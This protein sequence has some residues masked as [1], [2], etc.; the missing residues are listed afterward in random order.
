MKFLD[1][2]TIVSIVG[3]LVEDAVAAASTL[4]TLRAVPAALFMIRLRREGSSLLTLRVLGLGLWGKHLRQIVHKEPSLL[5][6]GASVGDLEDPDDGSQIIIHGQLFLHLD[7]GDAHGEHGDNLLIGDPENLVP[8]LAEAL[9]VLAKRFA[10]VLMHRLEIILGGGALVR[11][12]E[13]GDKLTAQILPRSY[14]FM[15]K[16]HEPSP[17]SVLEGHGKPISHHTLVFMHGLNSD[18]V[19]L[20]KLDGVGGP[21]ITRADVRPKLVGPDHVALL[22]SE[23]KAPGVVDGLPGDLDVLASFADVVDGA[24]MIFA[25][26]LEGDACVFRSV[27]DDLA[28][29]LP[30]RRRRRTGNHLLGLGS[31]PISSTRGAVPRRWIW[32]PRALGSSQGR[33]FVGDGDKLGNSSVPPL[34]P[35]RGGLIA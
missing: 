29:G 9:D 31:L 20:E 21:I 10:L 18:D 5:G 1:Y 28:A 30:A 19:E 34:A 27:L 15:R 24:V 26:A 16:I 35:V 23:S 14:R 8:H 33:V 11:R 17:W 13:V 3:V 32:F 12:H 2:P 22:A 6:L 25:T 7:V 4:I